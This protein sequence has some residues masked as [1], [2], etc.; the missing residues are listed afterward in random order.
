MD[1]KKQKFC[2]KNGGRDV[3]EKKT[4]QANVDGNRGNDRTRKRWM[5]GAKNWLNLRGL[6]ITIQEAKKCVKNE[7]EWRSII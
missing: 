7:R 5:N 4:Y 2:W 6:T 3:S 1:E